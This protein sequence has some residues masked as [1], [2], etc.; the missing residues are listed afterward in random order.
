MVLVIEY[1]FDD[2]RNQRRRHSTSANHATSFGEL[3]QQI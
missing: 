1:R 3:N 2:S